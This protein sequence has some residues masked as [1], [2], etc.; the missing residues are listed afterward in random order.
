M[1][2][3]AELKSGLSTCFANCE[4]DPECFTL[5]DE[6]LKNIKTFK[7]EMTSSIAQID[8]KLTNLEST[9]E[10]ILRNQSTEI[11]KTSANLSLFIAKES[12]FMTDLQSLTTKNFEAQNFVIEN[13]AKAL[14]DSNDLTMSDFK[15]LFQDQVQKCEESNNETAESLNENLAGKID[16]ALESMKTTNDDHLAVVE[17]KVDTAINSLENKVDS[18][19]KSLDSKVDSAI[20]S[21]EESNQKLLETLQETILKATEARVDKAVELVD[22]K[23]AN[24]QLLRELEKTKHALEKKELE[25]KLKTMEENFKQQMAD[26]VKKQLEEFEKKL[27]EEDRP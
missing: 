20:K 24:A 8:K 9:C 25:E 3:Q 21:I 27:R 2:T 19:V 15:A 22:T 16:V 26:F 6:I 18:A 13:A 4:A 14:K 5:T 1:V 11:E 12:N 10:A 23:L 7:S 17:A